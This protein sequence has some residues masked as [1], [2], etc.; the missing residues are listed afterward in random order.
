MPLTF[1]DS[2]VKC[3]GDGYLGGSGFVVG[4]RGFRQRGGGGKTFSKL[5]LRFL[6]RS[7]SILLRS[8]SAS[9]CF[10]VLGSE[11]CLNEAFKTSNVLGRKNNSFFKY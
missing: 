1:H 9:K 11:S 6:F 8:L 2:M 10:S 3:F 5:D 7:G 4:S